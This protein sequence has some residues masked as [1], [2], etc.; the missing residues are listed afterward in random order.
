MTFGMRF[1]SRYVTC[2]LSGVGSIKFLLELSL[3]DAKLRGAGGDSLVVDDDVEFVVA[4]CGVHSLFLE[5]FAHHGKFCIGDVL[6]MAKIGV[7]DATV[8]HLDVVIEDH[9]HL[10]GVLSDAVCAD[11][12][13]VDA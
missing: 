8:W 10:G 13:C 11:H 6:R 9:R 1:N 5:T 4:L 7:A 12:G 2:G 3:A